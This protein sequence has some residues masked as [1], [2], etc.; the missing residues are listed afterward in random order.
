M[1][2]LR[3][4]LIFFLLFACICNGQRSFQGAPMSFSSGID[5]GYMT[6]YVDLG[7]LEF[8]VLGSEYDKEEYQ[9]GKVLFEGEVQTFYFR[10]NSFRDRVELKDRSERV[11]HL[12]KNPALQPFFGGKIYM[13]LHYND[14]DGMLK[15]GYFVPLNR[16][17]VV[18]F[19]KPRKIFQQASRP[20]NGYDNF[21]DPE[22]KDVS[23]YYIRIDE[24]IKPIKL[25][26]R[27]LLKT[28]DK[29]PAEIR[30]FLSNQHPD[31]KSEKGALALI[32]YYN[33]LL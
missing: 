19:Y 6:D 22:I 5:P 32:K 4:I 29:H 31:L 33:S 26:R 25:R 30:K 14:E 13:L 11:F 12:K 21:H 3:L 7:P 9:I 23:A 17:K 10:F 1:K 2:G 16:G 8:E 15:M 24:Y 20:V 28:L 18:L 27:I